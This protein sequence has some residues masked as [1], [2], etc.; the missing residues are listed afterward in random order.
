MNKIKV[1]LVEDEVIIRN[2]IKNSINWEAEGY[3]FVGEASDGEL[4]YPKILS[5]R[6]DILITDI[7]MPFM[8]GLELSRLAKKEL[9]DLRILILSGYDDFQYAKE[10]IR[11]GVTEY[12]LK[13]ISSAR[14]LESLNMVAQE[15][16]QE[17]EEKEWM[18]AYI[19]DAKE[20]LSQERR[21]LLDRLLSGEAFSLS[22]V[23]E[24][25]KRL[26]MNLSAQFYMLLV[27]NLI[28]DKEDQIPYE[29]ITMISEMIMQLEEQSQKIAVIERGIEGWIILISEESEEKVKEQVA[30]VVA[31]LHSGMKAF[32]DA[33]Y[34][35]GVGSI[36]SRLRKLK[37]SYK[38]ARHA[39]SGR[40]NHEANQIISVER[41]EQATAEAD[42]SV[43]GLEGLE[44][45]RKMMERFLNN[46]T[47]AEIDS[48]VQIYISGMNEDNLKSNLMRQYLIMDIYIMVMSFCE[49]LKA[50]EDGLRK[51]GEELKLAMQKIHTTSEIKNYI[52]RLLSM[53]LELRE[54]TS[55]DKYSEVIQ[56]AKEIIK[57][58]YM[59]D[60]ISLNM[61]AAGVGM[62]PSYF[63][64]VFSKETEK[65][66][67]EYLTE[68]RIEK[69]KELLMC[70]SMKTSEIGFE[71]G[72]KDAH[73]FSS[74]FKKV[75]GCTP[76]EYRIRGKE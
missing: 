20:T 33:D 13:P 7:K 69:A 5:T 65:T 21:H 75:Q 30:H 9:P 56:K 11:I 48:F 49:K 64:S 28:P 24:D 50:E 67:V 55:M 54:A 41:L 68:I 51:E 47:K 63:S 44:Q 14:L 17:L 18:Q 22:E 57:A 76:K 34:F 71:V 2:G 59:T 52:R 74:I 42:F 15:I 19:E 8:D 4:A 27:F 25:G 10:A 23:L 12:L 35:G 16:H 39:F 46:G 32:P 61:V 26:N 62:S 37:V 40:F 31:E 60:T 3:E 66:F 70:S 45:S 72:Y 53:A 73:Y 43:K 38:E 6:P 36:E 1:F 58:Q 29:K